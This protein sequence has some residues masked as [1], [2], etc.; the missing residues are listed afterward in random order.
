VVVAMEGFNGH[1]R[2]MDSEIRVR[3]Y[4]LFNVN[5][6]KLVPVRLKKIDNQAFGG[7]K[8]NIA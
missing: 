4:R 2:P 1:A 6:V 7:S 3:G 5:N 8:A